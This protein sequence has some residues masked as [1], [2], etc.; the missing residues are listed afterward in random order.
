VT[1][2]DIPDIERPAFFAGQRLT[3]ADLTAAQA[4]HRELRWLH[5]RGLHTWG[6]AFGLAVVGERGEG[7]VTVVPGYAVDCQGRDI[8]VDDELVVPVPSV[9][10]SAGV[11]A[12][13]YLTVS[14]QDDTDQPILQNGE[15]VCFDDG[16]TRRAEGGLVRWQK[17]GDPRAGLDVILARGDILDC[18]L[19]APVSAAERRDAR[20][21]QQP[22]VAAGSSSGATAW[23]AWTSTGGE[24][25]GL[26]ATVDTSA[27]GFGSTPRYVAHVVGAR[28][29]TE[30]P[31][32]G[33]VIDGFTSIAENDRNGFELRVLLP[34]G[35]KAG[36]K[37][38]INPAALLDGD[39]LLKAVQDWYVVWLG[40]EG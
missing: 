23:S 24:V 14:Y 38:P 36:L 19:D 35:L 1:K 32:A 33:V 21:A 29:G 28:L 25:I 12:T 18:V 2:A 39:D 22:Y 10:G 31:A 26:T 40:V 9:A 13:W 37:V 11:P 34:R 20:P 30:A 17:A 27:A 7:A 3:A 15:G 5:N 8:V 4:F 6:I 16:A